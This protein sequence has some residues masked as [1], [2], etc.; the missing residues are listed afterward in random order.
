MGAI[1]N[2]HIF[3]AY[4]NLAIDGLIKTL[5]FIAKKLDT[6]KQL[7]SWDIKHVITLIDSIFDQ[8]PQNNLEQ[9]VEGYLPW[10]KP[11][12]EMKTPKKGERQSDKL[13]IEYKT[14]ITA[15]A[16]LL[17][18][19]R[20]YY[21]HYYHDPIC[22]Y[23][24]GYD[25]PSSL[26]C[27]YDSAINII[28][29]RFQ[30]EEKEIEHLRRYTRKKGRVVLKTEDDHFYYTLVNNNDLS[31]KGYAFFISM[32]LERKYSYLFL[33]KLSGFK[34]GDSLQYRLTLEVF[35]A[36]STKPPVERLRTTKDTKQDRAL[37]IL[38]ELSRIPIELYQTL[39][40]K[41]REMYNETLQPTDAEDPYGLPDRSRIRFRSRFEAFALH[42]LDKQADFKEIGFYTYLGNYFHNGYQ[43]TRVDR[44]TKDRYINFQLAGFC[45]NI[46]DISAKKLSEA[47]NVKS[48]DISTDSIPDINSFEPYLV[49]STPHYIVNG[50]NIGIKVLPEGKD[51]Y[52][53]I[54]EKGAKMPIADFWLSKYELPAML[55]YTYL[56]NNNIHKSHCPLSVKDI[57]E[58][59]IHKSTKQKHPEERS[60]LMLRRVMKAIF[61]TDSKL[62]EVE[63]IKSQKSAFGKRQHEILKAGRIA[64]T[65]VRDMLW[66]QPSKNNGRDK[67][68]EPNFQAIQV[69][70][71]YFGI[72]RNDLT[73]IFTRA[74]L[75]NSSNPHP[76]LAQ[77]GTNYTSLIEFYIAYL[78]ER[79]VYFSRIQKKILQGKLNIQCHPLRDLQREPNKPQDKEEAIFLPRGLFNEAIINC[80]K[81]SKLKQLIESPTREKSP[82]LN[83]S[84]LIQNYFRTYFEDQS[85]EFYAQ[86][87]NYRLFDK[88]SP[89][90]G[91]SKS[92]LSLEQRIKKMEE[93]RPSK[94]PVA[95]ANK[96]LE[97]EDRLYRKNYN[98]ICDNESIIRLYQIQDILLFM[99]TKEYL[100]SDLYNRINKYKL[101]NVKGILN[102]RVSYLI[103]LNPLKIQGEDI[104]IKD[105]GKLFY[106][107]H[108]TRISSLNKVLSKVKR[109]NS[110]SSSVKIQPYENYKRECLDFE[111]AQ[112]QIIPIIHS[113]EIAMVS[114]FPDLKKATPGNYYDFNELITEYEKRTKQ[115][116]DSSF[117]IKTRNMFLHDKYEAECIKE[118]SD[119]F[120]YAKKI[121]AEFK[122][123]IEN[124]KL[125]DLSNDSSA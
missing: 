70:L 50:N 7:S 21:T 33:K 65:L 72:R 58:R 22:I 100:P 14:I 81:K 97:K 34:R 35:T 107:H 13:C 59:S 119:D 5:N 88:L 27:I 125:E 26:N 75:I 47:L 82:A 8:N 120:V 110:I 91:K 79:K 61:W 124:I 108:D 114:M 2:K 96:L 42:F 111:E 45:K 117:L 121:M 52:P 36:L 19:V 6:Q 102:E 11:I 57:I 51:T 9:V 105:Y 41:Y 29:E 55:F 49:Q 10:I 92:Y 12:I 17:N 16:S 20:N 113:F 66:L 112:I 15:F 30:A 48:I 122:M 87:R 73:E 25:I 78:K 104:K 118:I 43:K 31:E 85:Q 95:E 63:R 4:A 56:R 99:M 60:E 3:A 69:S 103:D 54:D 123:K 93:L 18:D 116:I 28:K 83:V 101:E 76:F 1:E 40:P 115:K 86:P 32:F 109:N 90:K 38:N 67:V 44:E 24:G 98:E 74:G 64:E 77:I 84:Y 80:L 23:P 68:T 106:I 46:Q 53:T 94:I 37:D 39:E 62:N 89:N 71:A